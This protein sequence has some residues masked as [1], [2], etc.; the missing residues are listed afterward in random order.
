MKKFIGIVF[1]FI[2]ASAVFGLDAVNFTSPVDNAGIKG[3]ILLHASTAGNAENMT[4]SFFN[5]TAFQDIAVLKISGTSFSVTKSPVNQE[6]VQVRALA[7]NGS[8]VL[9]AAKTVTIDNQGPQI[10]NLSI[11]K[12]QYGFLPSGVPTTV[13]TTSTDNLKIKNVTCILSPAEDVTVTNISSQYSCTF[14]PS[15]QSAYTVTM[16]VSD[17]AGSQSS[18]TGTFTTLSQSSAAITTIPVTISNMTAQDQI[19]TRTVTLTNDGQTT[20]NDVVVRNLNDQTTSACAQSLDPQA[21]CQANITVLIPGSTTPQTLEYFLSGEWT[22]VAGNHQDFTTIGKQAAV[23]QITIAP[24]R[25]V[26]ASPAPV[27]I[28]SPHG[29]NNTGFLF[30]LENTGNVIVSDISITYIPSPSVGIVLDIATTQ[31]ANLA[32]GSDIIIPVTVSVPRFTA[33]GNYSGNIRITSNAGTYNLPVSVIVPADFSVV[34]TG[35][36]FPAGSPS[37]VYVKKDSE[38]L[39]N[40]G[41]VPVTLTFTYAGD[42]FTY[43]MDNAHTTAS[44][45]LNAGEKKVFHVYNARTNPLSAY[46]LSITAKNATT[47]QFTKSL[48][49]LIDGN[50]PSV[51]IIN[52]A[53]GAFVNGMIPFNAGAVDDKHLER[54]EFFAGNTLIKNDTSLSFSSQLNTSAYPE[55][56]LALQAKAFDA[57]GNMNSSEIT[58]NVNNQDNAP[59]VAFTYPDYSLLEETVDTTLNATK[60]F[61]SPDGKDLFFSGATAHLAVAINQQ[62]GI[63]TLTPPA[64]FFG[65]DNVTLTATDTSGLNATD[66]IRVT[67]TNVNDVP[68]VPV[69]ISP[70]NGA[71]VANPTGNA[72]LQWQRGA[73][74]D[75]DQLSYKVEISNESSGS[76]VIFSHMTEDNNITVLGL[77]LNHSYYW[78]VA[79]FDNHNYSAFSPLRGFT[80]MS[81]LPP[82]ID[83]IEWNNS[84]TTGNGSTVPVMEGS[85]LTIMPVISDPD[86]DSFTVS[87]SLDNGINQAGN[88]FSYTPG[89]NESGTHSLFLRAVDNHSN[90][91]SAVIMINVQDTNH[92]PVLSEHSINA[93]VNEKMRYSQLISASDEDIA[94][95][96]SLTFSENSPVATITKLNQTTANFSF[97]ANTPGVYNTTITVVDIQGTSDT[98]QAVITVQNINDAPVISSSTPTTLTVAFAP[99]TNKTFSITAA[100]EDN[101]NLT[102]TWKKDAAVIGS[103]P[104][105]VF[106]SAAAGTFNVSVTVSDGQVST[107]HSWRVIVSNLPVTEGFDGATTDFS[108]VPDLNNVPGVVLELS[109]FGKIEFLGPINMSGMIDLVNN[110]KIGRVVAVNSGELPRLS[111]PARVTL[112]KQSYTT[113]PAILFSNGFTTN[114]SLV[115][116]RCNSCNVSSYSPVP[117]T[118]DGTVV[119]TVPGFSSYRAGDDPAVTNH[120]P[121]FIT[122]PL[123]TAR[124]NQTYVYAPGT[125]DGDGDAITLSLEQGPG[126]MTMVN[127][128]ISYSPTAAQVGFQH[129]IIKA[130]DGIAT[131][132]QEYQLEV[133]PE[134]KMVISQ[135]D[136]RIDGKKESRLQDGDTIN[137][138]AAP[139]SSVQF[140]V[141]VENLYSRSE[142]VDIEDVE[143]TVTIRDIDDGDDIDEIS[144]EVDIQADDTETANLDFAI[145]LQVDEDDYVVVIEVEGRDKFGNRYRETQNVKLTVQKER[146]ELLIQSFSL[147]NEV[148]A[149]DRRGSASVTVYNLGRD[150]EDDVV[151]ELVNSQLGIKSKVENLRLQEGTD[152]DAEYRH[153]FAFSVPGDAGS[154]LYPL[155]INAYYDINS[156]SATKSVALE[157]QDCQAAQPIVPS[158]PTVPSGSASSGSEIT[159]VQLVPGTTSFIGSGQTIVS[160]PQGTRQPSVTFRDS[161]SYIIGLVIAF[162]VMLGIIIYLFGVLLFS[163]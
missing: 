150:R 38:F 116:Q 3:T 162:I 70:V 79:A 157:V 39:N 2:L 122:S 80:L 14:T 147:D 97:L 25:Q 53:N 9:S 131:S 18:S 100:D 30:T 48:Q 10:A 135:I 62:T 29:T 74:A 107:Q 134:T 71:L 75:N 143:V 49:V 16:T 1:L 146:H 8:R 51:S 137:K 15:V 7:Q 99:G 127:G 59:I 31:L 81:N 43:I 55:G 4:F 50:A 108:S 91:G 58:V 28:I 140:E 68:T 124:V 153:T 66:T 33:P 138:E 64:D 125:I 34:E 42:F 105:Q 114:A 45:T 94:F 21:A 96:D 44:L 109:E 128:V 145:P 158:R 26:A 104:S 87:W 144:N 89:F 123:T 23:W 72:S 102:Y 67:V 142:D 56:S 37:T 63:V 5:G 130:T 112:R 82:A 36:T 12:N 155:T 163:K 83:R 11:N 47:T 35:D 136:V 17:L 40:T 119:F 111:V 148:V 151:I 121:V 32:A 156:L 152:S 141:E 120:A 86:G 110:V 78:H 57:A 19:I 126:G 54:I 95:G 159:E 118:T 73:D 24:N 6:N 61:S 117:P 52:P 85:T 90:E 65:T 88:T 154:G 76:P 22:D 113:A 103:S 106:S 84:N 161:E 149:C 98:A 139:G 13:S 27:S 41:N 129:V 77:D 60:I 133:K 69:I 132:R 115:N 93:L 160:T 92:V 20:I 46:S 101:D